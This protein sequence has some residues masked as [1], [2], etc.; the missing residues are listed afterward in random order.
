VLWDRV[1][2]LHVH[3]Y[4]VYNIRWIALRARLRTTAVMEDLSW[5]CTA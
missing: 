3:S 2:S 4:G 5:A 1:F